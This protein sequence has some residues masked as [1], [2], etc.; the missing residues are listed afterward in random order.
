MKCPKHGVR[1]RQGPTQLWCVPCLKEAV[2]APPTARYMLG[3]PLTPDE[4]KFLGEIELDNHLAQS[5]PVRA[6]E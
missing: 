6:E 3:P 1:M 4:H 5:A 2:Y